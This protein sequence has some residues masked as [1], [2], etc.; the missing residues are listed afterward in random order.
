MNATRKFFINS[1]HNSHVV[2]E[3][4]PRGCR[5]VSKSFRS[6]NEAEAALTALKRSDAL[7]I[8]T[9]RFNDMIRARIEHEFRNGPAVD[10]ASFGY[11]HGWIAVAGFNFCSDEMVG[12]NNQPYLD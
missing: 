8:A 6:K 10:E 9:A 1:F 5:A 11:K 4:L 7:T 2:M 3:M 12:P